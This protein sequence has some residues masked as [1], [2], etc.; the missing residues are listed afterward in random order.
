MIIF[1]LVKGELVEKGLMRR[2][3][4]GFKGEDSEYVFT[5]NKEQADLRGDDDGDK[6]VWAVSSGR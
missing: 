3:P 4:A 1:C 6:N 5:W 2:M